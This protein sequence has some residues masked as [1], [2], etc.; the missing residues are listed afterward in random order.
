M[1]FFISLFLVTLLPV[2]IIAQKSAIK[3][4][5]SNRF[6][7]TGKTINA[8]TEASLPGASIYIPDL[9]IGVASDVNGN[10]T[11]PNVPSGTY[12]I[13]VGYVGV[14]NHCLQEDIVSL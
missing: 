6:S 2:I 11:L 3:F 10:Y 13:E 7:I 5:R 1:K 8:K 12:I 9:K 14:Y 4:N